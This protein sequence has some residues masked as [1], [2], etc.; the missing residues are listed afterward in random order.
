M[1][2]TTTIMLLATTLAFAGC[3]LIGGEKKDG[4]DEPAA[5][6]KTGD[7]AAGPNDADKGKFIKAY[8]EAACAV[9]TSK[10]LTK[11]VEMTRSVYEKHGFNQMSY[12]AAT[13]TWAKDPGVEAALKEGMSKCAPPPAGPASADAAKPSEGDAAKP[14]E[15]DAAKPAEGDAAKPAEGD[16]VKPA[17]G[18]AAAAAKPEPKAHAHAGKWS[19]SMTSKD[20]TGGIKFTVKD[21]GSLMGEVRG[22]KPTSF[23]I[24]FAGTVKGGKFQLNGRKKGA[25]H[26]AFLRGAVDK[27]GVVVGEWDGTVAK[28]RQKGTWRAAKGK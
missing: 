21:D 5:G 12:A 14:A 4:G 19:G 3:D 27:K 13:K 15:G 17:D 1:R 11:A 18:A 16:A 24:S 2:R 22:T 20:V 6:D 10:D 23:I 8:V 25:T 26:H 7:K 28:K 9:K